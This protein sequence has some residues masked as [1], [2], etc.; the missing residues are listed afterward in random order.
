MLSSY[1]LT[2][3]QGLSPCSP[4][5]TKRPY[6]FHNLLCEKLQVSFILSFWGE[7]RSK[8]SGPFYVKTYY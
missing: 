3:F 1:E 5:F 6:Q 2:Q 7:I 4:L 8:D